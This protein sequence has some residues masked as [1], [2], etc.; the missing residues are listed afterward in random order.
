[1]IGRVAFFNGDKKAAALRRHFPA[2]DQF[3]FNPSAVFA[4]D[5]DGARLQMYRQIAAGWPQKLDRI[6]GRH[7]AGHFSQIELFLQGPRRRPIAMAI[8]Q[9][10]YDPAI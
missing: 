1:M 8:Q 5:F 6:F 7:R 10:S 9:G 2:A 4:D 3:A